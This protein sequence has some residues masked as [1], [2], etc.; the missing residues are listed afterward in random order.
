MSC[1]RIYVVLFLFVRVA[2]CSYYIHRLRTF[3]MLYRTCAL[4][5]AAID[6]RVLWFFIWR[7]QKFIHEIYSAKTF[8]KTFSEMF[9]KNQF[10]ILKINLS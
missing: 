9:F 7:A 6:V 4:F 8:L 10:Q 1:A 5:Y 2:G 3:L